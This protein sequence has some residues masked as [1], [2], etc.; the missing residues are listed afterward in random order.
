MILIEGRTSSVKRFC[1]VMNMPPP[2]KQNAH[3][4][5]NKAILK[6]CS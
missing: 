4:K 1:G 3:C 2:P 6:A 5:N